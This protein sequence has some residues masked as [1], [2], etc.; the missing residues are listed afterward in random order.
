MTV[1]TPRVLV[2]SE[3]RIT[4]R[5]VEMTFADQPVELVVAADGRTGVEQWQAKPPA[6]LVVDFTMGPPDGLTMARQVRDAQGDAAPPVILMAG[7]GETVDDGVLASAGVRGVLRKPLDS[8]QLIDAVRGAIR[9]GRRT[10]AEP[11]LWR[12]AYEEASPETA[13]TSSAAVGSEEVAAVAVEDVASVTVAPADPEPSAVGA[14]LAAL[15]PETPAS[16]TDDPAGD[17]LRAVV[18]APVASGPS[19]ADALAAAAAALD[20]SLGAPAA[21]PAEALLAAPIDRPLADEDLQRVAE[22]VVAIWSGDAARE[23][24]VSEL[25]AERVERVAPAAANAAAERLVRE[26]APAV[27]AEVARLVVTDVSERLVREEIARIRSA[28]ATR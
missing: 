18:D 6:V 20:P 2:V 17:L 11:A 7:Q 27:V 22:R 1:S 9:D 12:P 14:L 5:V 3:S 15:E 4:R 21:P 19:V 26:L 10:V 16:G 23:R 8:M 24:H 28:P 13:V 25:V